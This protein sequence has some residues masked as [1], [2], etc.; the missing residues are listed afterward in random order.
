MNQNLNEQIAAFYQKWFKCMEDSDIEGFLSLF[1]KDFYFKGP[2]QPAIISRSALREGLE[3]Y[4]RD[5]NS[6]VEW[7][8][9]EVEFFDDRAIV[10]LR[11]SVTLTNRQSGEEQNFKGIHLAVLIKKDNV[12]YCKNDVSSLDHPV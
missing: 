7:N 1:T 4:H 2:A 3:E 11:E 9:E 10:R 12:W 6:S 8:I 5:F